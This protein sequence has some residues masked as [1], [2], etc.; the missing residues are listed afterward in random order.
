MNKI[1][2]ELADV[3][4]EGES[5]DDVLGNL[6]S[7]SQTEENSEKEKP[8]EG[9]VP[10]EDNI[11]FHKHPRWIE[12]ENELNE[13]RE[14]DEQTARELAELKASRSENTEVPPWFSELYG[15][16]KV[17]WQKYSAQ[18]EAKFAELE[19]RVV[20]RFEEKQTKAQKEAE[21]WEKWVDSEMVR[22]E[23]TGNKFDRNELTKVMLEYSPTDNN[24]NLD[25]NKGYKIYEALKGKPDSARSEARK[26]IADTTSVATTRGEPAKKDYMTAADLRNRSWGSLD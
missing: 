2:N 18:E 22:L 15:D 20:A 19:S 5:L 6:A 1:E 10:V 3:K 7:E 23:S 8:A 13:L 14:R 26:Q 16:N 24:N 9:V 25:F 17:A 12:R 21:H 4:N 11:P